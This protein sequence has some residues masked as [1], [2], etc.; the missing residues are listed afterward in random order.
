MPP[1]RRAA[2][3]AAT[4]ENKRF[5]SVMVDETAE[6]RSWSAPVIIALPVDPVTAQDGVVYDPVGGWYSGDR[7]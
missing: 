1:K 4:E 7:C 3:D 5:K 6:R 2:A